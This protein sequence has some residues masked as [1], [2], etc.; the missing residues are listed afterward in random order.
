MIRLTLESL[1]VTFE[2]LRCFGNLL[3][4]VEKVARIIG[5][6][7]SALFVGFRSFGHTLH[8]RA[9][10]E[11]FIVVVEHFLILQ[12]KAVLHDRCFLRAE[13]E[14]RIDF[15]TLSRLLEADYLGEQR[16]L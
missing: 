3:L 6:E 8:I 4:K 2:C 11:S 12:T 5:H 1:N 16:L 13:L 7:S 10:I 14:P 9:E 15:I